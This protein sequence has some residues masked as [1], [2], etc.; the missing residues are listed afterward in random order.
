[1]LVTM[2]QDK[3]FKDLGCPVELASALH[4]TR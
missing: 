1:L 4:N 2:G 3:V